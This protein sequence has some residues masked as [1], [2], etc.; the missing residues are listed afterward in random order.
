MNDCLVTGMSNVGKTCFVINFAEYMG[1]KEL[2]FHIKQLAGYTSISSYSPVEAREKLIS[3]DENSTR[4]VH[5][6]NLEIPKGKTFKEIKIIDSCG[7]SEGIHPDKAIR[8]AMANT[9]RLIRE[10]QFIF[11]MIDLTNIKND[12]NNLLFSIDKMILEY[13]SLEKKYAI[14]ANKIDLQS[15]QKN[16]E[17]LKAR[18]KNIL[19]IPISA[20]YKKGFQ[21]VKKMVYTYV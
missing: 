2:K 16:I 20:L 14:L 10:S 7:L 12:D 3:V 13:A 1:L 17:L 8:L 21:D 4:E 18:Y 9:L 11:H 6:I 5:T 19:I 15:A